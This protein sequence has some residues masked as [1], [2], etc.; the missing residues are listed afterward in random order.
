MRTQLLMPSLLALLVLAASCS[1]LGQFNPAAFYHIIAKHSGKCLTVAGR[2]DADGDQIIQADCNDAEDS[3]KW[4][5]IPTRGT[6]KIV[7]KLSSKALDVRAAA[8][9]NG[10]TV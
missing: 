9:D 7:S 10:A 3:Q 5:V 6:F 2:G 1:A 4:Q 8:M